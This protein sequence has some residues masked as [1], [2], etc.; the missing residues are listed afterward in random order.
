MVID[1]YY[2]IWYYL[3]QFKWKSSHK[4]LFLKYEFF[5]Q[6]TYSGIP[7]FLPNSGT[8]DDFAALKLLTLVT[9]NVPKCLL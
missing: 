4:H 7:G 9:Q 6:I 8:N 3:C 5:L 1:D 2:Y